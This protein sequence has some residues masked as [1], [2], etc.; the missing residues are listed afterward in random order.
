M[1][2]Y[3]YIYRYICLSNKAACLFKHAAFLSEK[4]DPLEER[5]SECRIRGWRAVSAP[6]LQG[7]GSLKRSVTLTDAGIISPSDYLALWNWSG[8]VK[9]GE[10]K[11]N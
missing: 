10:L 7:E 1:Y 3:M 5:P 4:K 6:G 9:K 11:Q 8:F 2:V